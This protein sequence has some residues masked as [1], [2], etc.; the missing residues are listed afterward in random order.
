MRLQSMQTVYQVRRETG[1]IFWC[2][3]C[4]VK[5]THMVATIIQAI[6]EALHRQA[7]AAAHRQGM[8]ADKSYLH[9]LLNTPSLKVF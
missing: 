9:R 5:E 6:T 4:R 7:V 2:I 8:G 3:R 1:K